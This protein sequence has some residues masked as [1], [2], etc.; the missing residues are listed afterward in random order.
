MSR[1]TLRI[2]FITVIVSVACPLLS[3]TSYSVGGC[4]PKAVNFPTIGAA[5]TFVLPGTTILVCPGVYPE[6]VT[7]TQPLTLQ[8]VTYNNM[9]RPVII[10]NPNGIL[11][12][13]VTS[14]IGQGFYAQ[15][16]VQNVNPAGS[17]NITGITVDGSG[18]NLGCNSADGL[19]GIFYASGTSGT[20]NHVTARNQ[21]SSGCGVGIWAEN[22]V[23]P[24]Q[25]VTI[26]NSSI[27][28][29][30]SD[31]ITALSNQNP[32][33]LA[34][35]LRGNFLTA[36][37]N[38]PGVGID[39]SHINGAITG[40]VIT[41]LGLGAVS[42]AKGGPIAVSSNVIADQPAGSEGFLLLDSTTASSNLVANAFTAFYVGDT[43][44]T[45]KSNTVMNVNVA[46]FFSCTPGSSTTKNIVNDAQTGFGNASTTVLG[47]AIYNLDTIQSGSCP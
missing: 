8:G 35:T 9:G 21:Q 5:V 29:F 43:G 24:N 38:G 36:A 7:I 45:I 28:N 31:G 23:G 4:V 19:A 6:Q 10:V 16:L 47:N 40:N 41:N 22:G 37:T 25:N 20:I 3:A 33:T 14:V 42:D 26:E 46:V 18:G 34:A 39:A 2:L 1:I 11:T 44:P 13:N 17:V 12:P 27:R 30:D 32:S 15:V